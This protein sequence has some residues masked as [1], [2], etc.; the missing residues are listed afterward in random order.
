MATLEWFDWLNAFGEPLA[1]NFLY[2]DSVD[3]RFFSLLV[4]LHIGLP[5]LL[6]LGMWVHIQRLTRPDTR[7]AL[8]LGWGATLAL[9]A[10]SLVLPV[11]SHAPANLAQAPQ[12]LAFDWFYLAPNALVYTWSAGTLW[13][14]AGAVTLLLAAVPSAAT[15]AAGTG[16]A[17]GSGKLQRL[18]ALL[19]RLPLRGGDDGAAPGQAARRPDRCRRTSLCASCGICAGACPSSTPFRSIAEL[20]SGI[21]MPQLPIGQLRSRLKA[22]LARLKGEVRI[23]VFGCDQGADVRALQAADTAAVSLLCA[24]QLP[25]AFVE[26]ALRSGAQGVLIAACPDG[27][28][29]YRLGTRLT[30]E[31]MQG[32]REP[33]LR[34]TVAP[35]EWRMVAAGHHDLAR[36]RQELDAFRGALKA[37]ACRHWDRTGQEAADA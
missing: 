2:G 16:S 3:D 5:L 25:P 30:L 33:H 20:V 12:V 21:D 31:R 36:V 26:Y 28:C 32:V 34:R 7:P 24:G 8:A 4:F 9:L 11:E 37:R 35:A 1:R 13:M 17:G 22:Q 10:L 27:G 6:L 23:V 15:F 19:C 18:R 29:E 14:L